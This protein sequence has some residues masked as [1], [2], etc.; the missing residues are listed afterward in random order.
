M[1]ATISKKL[2][3]D[4][5]LLIG[6]FEK[7]YLLVR[8]GIYSKSKENLLYILQSIRF[9]IDERYLNKFLRTS[10]TIK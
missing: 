5:N 7:F 6:E 8:S 2:Y 4:L 3:G 10:V 9:R 1:M